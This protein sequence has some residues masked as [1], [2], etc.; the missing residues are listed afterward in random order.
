MLSQAQAVM[1]KTKPELVLGGTTGLGYDGCTSTF[2][3]AV[4]HCDQEYPHLVMREN[5]E[6]LH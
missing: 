2:W 4:K 6:N 3:Q 1:L 5:R